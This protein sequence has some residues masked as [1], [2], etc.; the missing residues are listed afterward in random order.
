[1]YSVWG[2]TCLCPRP[3]VLLFLHIILDTK[4]ASP[5]TWSHNSLSCACSLSSILIKI[6]PS[7]VISSL[8]NLNL[9]FINDNHLL[10][11][12]ESS[13]STYLSLYTKSVFP[14]LYGGSM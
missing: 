7:S 5:N 12:H 11:L 1:T 2:I 9:L 13:L 4:L 10:C 6:T 14:V 3:C 8:A